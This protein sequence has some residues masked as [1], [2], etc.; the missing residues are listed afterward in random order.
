MHGGGVDSLDG[1]RT[2]ELALLV[3]PSFDGRGDGS[4]ETPGTDLFVC[5]STYMEIL[6]VRVTVN[7]KS[8]K[9]EPWLAIRAAEVISECEFGRYIIGRQVGPSAICT[10]EAPRALGSCTA[11][12]LRTC[13]MPTPPPLLSLCAPL[14]LSPLCQT[15][16]LPSSVIHPFHPL[17]ATRLFSR[18]PETCAALPHLRL[19]RPSARVNMSLASKLSINDVDLKG[20]RVLIRV[21][22]ASALARPRR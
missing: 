17:V 2:P 5:T 19:S 6:W 12:P 16:H 1:C 14:S 9:R 4:I 11:P 21:S 8:D 10:V 18:L 22:P 7:T 13:P 3:S 15:P 20:K